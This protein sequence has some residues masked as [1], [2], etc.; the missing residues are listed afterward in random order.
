MSRSLKK[1]PYVEAKLLARVEKMNETDSDLSSSNDV[2]YS[3]NNSIVG[4]DTI[5]P[6]KISIA[7]S[8]FLLIVAFPADSLFL[9]LYINP[10]I[11]K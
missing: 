11:T 9:L 5:K 10:A 1:G 4:N 2:I 7:H 3:N 6:I 8:I